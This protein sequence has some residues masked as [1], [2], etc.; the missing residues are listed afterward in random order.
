M[1]RSRVGRLHN[2]GE[3]KVK[4]LRSKSMATLDRLPSVNFVTGFD[5]EV[6]NFLRTID[7][8]LEPYLKRSLDLVPYEVDLKQGVMY[9]LQS[10]GKRI[11]A[12]LCASVCELFC[13]SYLRALSFAAAIEHLQNFMLVHDDIADGDG[14][15]RGRPSIWQRFGIAHAITIGDIFI[16]LSA[17]AI[18]ESMY[19]QETKLKLLQIV[20]ECGIEVA[21][22]QSLD[23]NLRKNDAPSVEEYFQC[24]RK[25]TGAFL[26]MAIIGGGVIGGAGEKD[27]ITLQEFALQAGTAFQVKDDLI[28]LTGS[29]GRTIGSDILEGKRTLPLIH[30]LGQASSSERRRLLSILNK[31]RLATTAQEVRWVLKLYHKTGAIA[32]A[33]QTAEQLT[34]EASAHFCTLPESEAKFRLLRIIKYL[35]RRKH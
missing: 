3:G 29:K 32:Y 28:D 23:I 2:S 24:T 13:G 27:L 8:H 10:G 12:A 21:E 34:E 22:G 11:R 19:A 35:S 4:I 25:K 5:V 16:S 31:P 1:A 9:Q 14:E 7:R 33:E 18:L 20:S 15:R 26:A 6:E 17:L 30:A